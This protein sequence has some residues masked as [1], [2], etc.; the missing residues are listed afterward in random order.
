LSRHATSWTT[1]VVNRELIRSTAFIRA[2]RRYL[3]K[4]PQAAEEL[5]ATLL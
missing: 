2:T 3:K 5:E 4:H 1:C